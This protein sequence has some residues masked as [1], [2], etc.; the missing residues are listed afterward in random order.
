MNLK[1]ALLISL[2]SLTSPLISHSQQ[3]SPPASSSSTPPIYKPAAINGQQTGA[4][5]L[6]RNIRY[7][8]RAHNDPDLTSLDIYAPREGTRHPV[9]LWVHGGGWQNGSKNN[10]G[11]KP[12]AFTTAGYVFISIN[13]RLSPQ[14]QHPAH[15]QDLASAIAWVHN[16]I[17][18]YGGNPNA[19]SLMGHSAGAHLAALVATDE[20]YLKAERL[21]L[22]VLRSVV[23][24]DTGSYDLTQGGWKKE[25]VI[26][27]PVFGTDPVLWQDAS[28]ITHVVANKGIPPFQLFYADTRRSKQSQVQAFA[29]ELQS[30]GIKTVIIAAPNKTHRTINRE[31]GQPGDLITRQVLNFL[32]QH[33][34]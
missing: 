13:Y 14:V 3:V 5:T 25:E 27:P 30:A 29:Q 32:N 10:V 7:A 9:L 4:Y 21:T 34:R 17:K 24:L 15:V 16:R 12:H 8:T 22:N 31:L 20:R 1:Y 33:S 28:P 2:Y 23:C 6:V 18:A 11:N 19:I 26:Y